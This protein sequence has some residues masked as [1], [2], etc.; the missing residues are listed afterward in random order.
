M[1]KLKSKSSAAKRISFTKSGK[2]KR[3]KAY[4]R[5]QLSCKTRKRKRHLKKAV[6]Y[7]SKAEARNIRRLLP[8]S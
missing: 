4:R 6:A 8:Y 2:L 5:H 3:S 7:V 1:P